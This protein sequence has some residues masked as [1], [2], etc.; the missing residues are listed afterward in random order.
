M[1]AKQ[2][3][4][5][6]GLEAIARSVSNIFAGALRNTNKIKL[7]EGDP[8]TLV[9]SLS[10]Y[11]KNS[12]KILII[13]IN[14]MEAMRKA[15]YE[16]IRLYGMGDSSFSGRLIPSLYTPMKK[17]SNALLKEDNNEII[18]GC[19]LF[20]K[21]KNIDSNYSIDD[22]YSDIWCSYGYDDRFMA[23]IGQE[24]LCN[25]SFDGEGIVAEQNS[26]DED[27]VS[28]SEMFV[29]RVIDPR[30]NE[31]KV[32]VLDKTEDE[33]VLWTPGVLSQG[34]KIKNYRDDERHAIY[35]MPVNDFLHNLGLSNLIKRSYSIKER[36]EIIDIIQN[37]SQ[38]TDEELRTLP[39]VAKT[40]AGWWTDEINKSLSGSPLYTPST[41]EQL[42]ILRT[43]LTSNI[44]YSVARNPK[45]F[46]LTK[47]SWA[48]NEAREKAGITTFGIPHVDMNITPSKV[49]LLSD[50][51]ES[52]VLYDGKEIPTKNPQV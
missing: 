34:Y 8:S 50:G 9:T 33:T 19:R 13:S 10:N 41:E 36:S 48:L 28:A 2:E 20:L 38:L 47:N 27:I 22:R 15:L 21:L 26:I 6:E 24:T 5:K 37:L 40:A 49:T 23:R 7:S 14:E 4:T 29:G 25:I 16:A 39:I 31:T 18:R 52:T 3:F 11:A 51:I 12:D 1:E 45:Y 43:R 30:Y 46:C 17:L 35:Y 44:I 32:T 42:E